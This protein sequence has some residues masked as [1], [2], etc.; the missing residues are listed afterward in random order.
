MQA[1]EFYEE[2]LGVFTKEEFSEE[3]EELTLRIASLEE[4][5]EYLDKKQVLLESRTGRSHPGDGGN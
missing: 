1:I 5:L 4:A 2:A 3:W